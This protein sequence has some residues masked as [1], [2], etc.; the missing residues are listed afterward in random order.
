[1]LI[2]DAIGDTIFSVSSHVDAPGVIP[3][4]QGSRHPPLFCSKSRINAFACSGGNVGKYVGVDVPVGV[5]IGGFV[6]YKG[7]VGVVVGVLITVDVYIDL[8]G[9]TNEVFSIVALSVD[10]EE[11]LHPTTSMRKKTPYI[12]MITLL[13]I[14]IVNLHQ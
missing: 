3:H 5:G 11:F 13:V 12:H 6:G 4:Q 8:L 14:F 1:M 7:N 2:S 9:V 10:P